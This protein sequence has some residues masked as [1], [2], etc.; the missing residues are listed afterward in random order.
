MAHN[1]HLPN[2]HVIAIEMDSIDEQNDDADDLQMD[3]IENELVYPQDDASSQSSSASSSD[4][5]NRD[6]Q[7]AA[8]MPENSNVAPQSVG[9]NGSGS[10]TNEP[11]ID[12]IARDAAIVAA[13]PTN[14]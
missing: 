1:G 6:R 10:S 11:L 4:G 13:S 3:N 2:G 5:L 8:V 14:H 12:D 7:M 9:G